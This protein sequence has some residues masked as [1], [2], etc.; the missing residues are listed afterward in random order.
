MPDDTN[1]VSANA[2]TTNA[3]ASAPQ[4]KMKA[5]PLT[6]VMTIKNQEEYEK[7]N[8]LLTQI[9]SL[10]PDQNPV[11]AA[12][13]KLRIVHFARF[14]FL[15][16]N[17]RLAVM[18][19]YDGSFDNYINQFINVI[20]DVFNQLLVHMADAPPLPVQQHR[21]EFLAYVKKN[22]VPIIGPFYSAYPDLSVDDILAL[23][24]MP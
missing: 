7:L 3:A 20:G 16:N 22:D 23:A 10:P 5:S 17:T 9:Q 8:A 1:A 11:I 19:A 14:V 2:A 21:D 24:G 6:L 18:T 12:L 13:N 15:E 4:P